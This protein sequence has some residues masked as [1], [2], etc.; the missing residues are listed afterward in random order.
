M[1]KIESLIKKTY[2]ASVALRGAGAAQ[3][4]TALRML[5]DSL[6]E[7]KG[8]LLRANAR[9]LSRQEPGNPRNDRLMLN[10]Q[11]IRAIAASIRNISKLPDPTG[12]VLDKRVFHNGLRVEKISVPLGVVGAIYESSP[13]V[14]FDIAALCLRSRNACLLKGSQEA[15]QTNK[16]AIRLIRAA[17]KANGILPD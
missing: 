5:A 8:A 11:R 6:E 13:N 2:E 10:E 1:S 7:E 15:G 3:I 4:K 9:D 17:L 16:V 12:R 14:T